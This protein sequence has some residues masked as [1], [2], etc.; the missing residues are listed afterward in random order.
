VSFFIVMTAD[1]RGGLL[2]GILAPAIV[3]FLPYI[4]LTSGIAVLISGQAAVLAFGGNLIQKFVLFKSFSRANLDVLSGRSTIWKPAIDH[5]TDFQTI[6]L[7]GYGLFGQVGSGIYQY[8]N[9]ASF[10][11]AGLVDLHNFLLQS[12]FD[13]GYLGLVV[14]GLLYYFMGRSLHKRLIAAKLDLDTNLAITG[15]IY[16]ILIGSVSTIPSF[17]GQE[18]FFLFP[19]IWIAAGIK[20]GDKND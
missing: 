8:Q 15:L 2:F 14:A 18:L 19:F 9:Y 20:N 3:V 1:S 11:N 10:I 12:I 16:F 4:N 7:F 17:Y 13:I 5:L 6:H